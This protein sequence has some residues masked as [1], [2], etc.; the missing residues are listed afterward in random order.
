MIFKKEALGIGD[1]YLMAMIGALVGWKGVV[2]VFF[3]APMPGAVIGILYK[4]F[5]K[6]SEI[7]Y[8]PFLIFATLLLLYFPSFFYGWFN[9]VLFLLNKAFGA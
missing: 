7:P 3:I 6:D 4:V 8:G 1:I 2:L 5:T 9:D